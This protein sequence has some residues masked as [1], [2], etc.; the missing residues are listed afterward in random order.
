MSKTTIIGILGIIIAITTAAKGALTGGAGTIDYAAVV[1]QILLGIG[2]I[3]A[4]D[5]K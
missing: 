1:S 4:Q 2:L 3:K 5:Q